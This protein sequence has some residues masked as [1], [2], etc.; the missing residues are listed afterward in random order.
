MEAKIVE[1][2][3]GKNQR[4]YTCMTAGC[5]YMECMEICFSLQPRGTGE[6]VATNKSFTPLFARLHCNLSSSIKGEV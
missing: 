6:L 3:A 1:H 5:N 4:S 2:A